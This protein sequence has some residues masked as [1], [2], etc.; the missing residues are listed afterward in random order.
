M[1]RVKKS[2][3]FADI[4]L[5]DKESILKGIDKRIKLFDKR[6]KE[7]R[8]NG[9]SEL[10]NAQALGYRSGLLEAK[11]V[12]RKTFKEVTYGNNG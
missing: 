1:P 10:H 2:F 9:N 7:N 12:I 5:A 4:M 3:D 6:Y 8:A 11:K